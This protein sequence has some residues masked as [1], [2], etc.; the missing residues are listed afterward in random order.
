MNVDKLIGSNIRKYRTAY[1]MTLKELSDKIHKSIS[2][3]SKYEKGDISL[4]M[5]TFMDMAHI[6]NISPTLLLGCN[7]DM[8]TKDTDY[9]DSAADTLYMYTYDSQNRCIIQSLI[10]RYPAQNQDHTCKVQLFNDVKDFKQPGNC[11]GLYTGEYMKKGFI[12]TYILN[13]QLSKSEYVMISCVDNLTN[14]N[15]QIG[16]ITGLSNY[17][18]LPVA[19]KAI[20]SAIELTNKEAIIERLSFSKEDFKSIKKTQCLTVLNSR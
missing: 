2:T 16:I 1:N 20:I 6:F 8:T 10:E 14:P 5:T 11:A 9:S 12:E 4:D 18:M 15:Q 19:F 7:A 13:N 3:I 17:T